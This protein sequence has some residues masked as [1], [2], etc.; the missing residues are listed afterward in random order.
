MKTKKLLS[1]MLCVVMVLSNT[2]TYVSA[3]DLNVD[4]TSVTSNLETTIESYFENVK[5]TS[6]EFNNYE[7]IST[8]SDIEDEEFIDG[9]YDEEPEGGEETTKDAEE[10]SSKLEEVVEISEFESLVGETKKDGESTEGSPENV[11]EESSNIIKETANDLE[12]KSTSDSFESTSLVASISSENGDYNIIK[13]EIVA[14]TSDASED[15]D[16]SHLVSDDD[17]QSVYGNVEKIIATASDVGEDDS[18]TQLV[19][20]DVATSSE[21]KRKLVK[22]A[23]TSSLNTETLFGEVATSSDA[24]NNYHLSY[25]GIDYAPKI[26]EDAYSGLMGSSISSSYDSRDPSHN[27]ERGLSIVPPIRHQNPYGLCWAFSMIA[28]MES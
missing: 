25:M 6:D 17:N 23:T 21:I 26:P 19:S 18:V 7:R 22:I 10:S 2:M 4:S 28:Q 8:S 14:T 9:D 13:S 5:T 15:D 16:A 3:E 1:I 27:N 24:Y 20:D 11:L 12:E